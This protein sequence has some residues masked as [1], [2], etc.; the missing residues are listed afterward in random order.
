MV[1][2]CAHKCHQECQC[3]HTIC[4]GMREPEH[5]KSD[6]SEHELS[7]IASSTPLCWNSSWSEKVAALE[8]SVQLKGEN[9]NNPKRRHAQQVLMALRCCA[10][11]DELK[12]NYWWWPGK[13]RLKF[14][15][16]NAEVSADSHAIAFWEL[17]TVHKGT[18]LGNAIAYSTSHP[19]KRASELYF[20]WFWICPSNFFCTSFC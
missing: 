4:N 2:F 7:I 14:L 16:L 11:G 10:A 15:L 1:C 17:P 8:S 6:W 5:N 19:T 9:N 18:N 20:R 3:V 12:T 13:G